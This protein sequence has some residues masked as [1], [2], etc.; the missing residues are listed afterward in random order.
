MPIK[1]PNQKPVSAKLIYESGGPK[2]DEWHARDRF[3][4]RIIL[5][6]FGSGK[7]FVVCYEVLWL[8]LR[9][10]YQGKT[11][12]FV[13]K[14]HNQA[15]N[16]ILKKIIKKMIGGDVDKKI[17]GLP[18]GSYRITYTS[19]A[20]IEF[21]NG[22]R[23]VFM[24]HN[25]DGI[26]GWNA[27]IVVLDE[28]NKASEDVYY[29]LENRHSR[30]GVPGKYIIAANPSHPGHWLYTKFW[31]EY[32]ETGSF[33]EDCFGTSISLF[34]SK[35]VLP[36]KIKS[37]EQAYQHNPALYA[38]AV[39]GH[40]SDNSGQVY[41]QFDPDTHWLDSKNTANKKPVITDAY[42]ITCGLDFG[43]KDPTAFIM[44]AYNPENGVYYAFREYKKGGD[45]IR[46]HA[47]AI[48]NM[49]GEYA[50]R[51]TIYSDHDAQ[52]RSEYGALG[53][54]TSL[55]NK[56]LM[57][58]IDHIARLFAENRLLI[59]ENCKE[60]KR[61]LESYQ[62]PD[63]GKSKKDAPV[64]KDNHL[65]DALRYAIYSVTHASASKLY[66]PFEAPLQAPTELK[67]VSGYTMRGE[68]IYYSV[69]IPAPVKKP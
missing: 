19:P 36:A 69:P 17:P 12:L 22:S 57:P 51:P 44:V 68:P 54:S 65:L 45:L 64:D 9:G 18:K 26:D 43:Y 32:D 56:E 58:G 25:S 34:D 53:V 37:M 31:K 16:N 28:A 38:R 60:L 15:V 27:S 48:L 52:A 1:N 39:M 50:K 41:S 10:P 30:E 24:S 61:E 42:K 49:T 59:F 11:C 2:I 55:A 13:A 20:I 6:A 8:L 33:P 47:K 29:A 62:W 67:F 21:W 5:G 35:H 23:I 4:R 3:T 40:F 7:T 14:D 63:E 66:L 46:D